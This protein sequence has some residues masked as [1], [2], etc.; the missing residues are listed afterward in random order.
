[1]T[2][3][4]TEPV[5]S[6]NEPLQP[7]SIP[8]ASQSNLMKK[9]KKSLNWK[10]YT[11]LAVVGML[12][13]GGGYLIY[14]A[15]V[16]NTQNVN[17]IIDNSG[18]LPT[19]GDQTKPA[20]KT[21]QTGEPDHIS[22][23]DRKIEAP[24]IYITETN[25]DVYQEAL[26]RGAVHFPG[27][28]LP[29]EYGNPYIFGHS[30]DYAWK[31]GDYKKIFKELIDI[32][33]ETKVYITNH[34]GSLFVYVIKETKI[35]GPKDTSVLDQYNYER[36]MLTLQTSWPLNTALKRYIA[37]AELDELATYGPEEPVNTNQAN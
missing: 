13:A 16:N 22:I 28:V 31:A 25:E 6:I 35:V 36:K 14:N 15:W 9:K 21:L 17:A 37:V 32:P 24:V 18:R 4:I 10:A 26:T 12:M 19:S 20:R 30:S 23:P 7:E 8:L 1:M 3:P 2:V 29:G 5:K 34:D 27:T 11:V 33:L